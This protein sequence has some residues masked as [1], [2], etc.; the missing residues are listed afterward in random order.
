MM[1]LPYSSRCRHR[2]CPQRAIRAGVCLRHLEAL[3]A[4]RPLPWP[5]DLQPVKANE[6]A[7][8]KRL[9]LAQ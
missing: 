7:L 2:A 9:R 1:D 5:A 4:G 3:T 6:Y 8:R